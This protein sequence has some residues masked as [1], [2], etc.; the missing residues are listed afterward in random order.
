[1]PG[2]ACDVI[3]VLC[4]NKLLFLIKIERSNLAAVFWPFVNKQMAALGGSLCA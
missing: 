2:D 1:M 4:Y 3:I